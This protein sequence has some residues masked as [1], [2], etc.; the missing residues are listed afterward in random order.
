MRSLH[1]QGGDNRLIAQYLNTD[2][3]S[4]QEVWDWLDAPTE[5]Y[6]T[7]ELKRSGRPC[8]AGPLKRF[9]VMNGRCERCREAYSRACT[10][11]KM[12]SEQRQIEYLQIPSRYQTMSFATWRGDYPEEVKSFLADPTELLVLEGN[13][14]RGKTHLATAVLRKLVGEGESGLWADVPG[15]PDRLRDE[16]GGDRH[17]WHRLMTC[18]LLVLDDFGHQRHGDYATERLETCLRRRYQDKL[19]TLVT[20][21]LAESQIK[22]AN[23]SLG[24]RLYNHEPVLV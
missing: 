24:R 3:S 20:T 15:L 9:E 14:G 21:N 11:G 4:G 13:T 8:G 5:E 23:P 7:V 17:L 18:R 19:G 16:E 12:G 2:F 1:V 10:E 6:C 22:G